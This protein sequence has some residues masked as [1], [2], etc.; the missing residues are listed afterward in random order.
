MFNFYNVF[1]VETPLKLLS[2][3]RVINNSCLIQHN[4]SPKSQFQKQLNICILK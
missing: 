2:L 3:T 1:L 4:Q